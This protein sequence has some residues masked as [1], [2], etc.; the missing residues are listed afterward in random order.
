[1]IYEMRRDKDINHK[2]T[3]VLGRFTGEYI[4]IS[5]II[6]IYVFIYFFSL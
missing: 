4:I 3:I 2:S 1:M 6:L 5:I